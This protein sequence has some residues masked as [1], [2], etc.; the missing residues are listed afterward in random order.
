[1]SVF[2]LPCDRHARALLFV[3]ALAAAGCASLE[4]D[5]VAAPPDGGAVVMRAGTPLIVS[6]PPDPSTGYGWVLQSSDPKLFLIGGPDYTPEPRPPGLVGIA[7]TTTYR[8]RAKAPGTGSLEFAWQAPPG[9]P[10]A[11]ARTVRYEVTIAP[12]LPSTPWGLVGPAGADGQPTVKYW[13]F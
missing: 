4:R 11:P 8:F 10:P 13:F 7:N 1:M 9:Q 2:P 12:Q 5:E 3:M 6:L